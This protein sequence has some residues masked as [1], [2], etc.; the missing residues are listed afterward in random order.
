MLYYFK[1]ILM[2]SLGVHIKVKDFR[3]SEKFYSSLG[4]EKVFEYGPGKKVEED[5]SGSVFNTGDG[6]IEI[7]DGHRAVKPEIF[8]QEV[9]SSKISLVIQVLNLESIIKKCHRANIFIAVKP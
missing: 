2:K 3:K 6:T 8:K 4:F 5:Y 7:A 9:L 1:Y